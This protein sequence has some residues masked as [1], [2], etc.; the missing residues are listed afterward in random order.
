MSYP[1]TV[2]EA[3]IKILRHHDDEYMVPV[4]HVQWGG[5]LKRF[6][7]LGR[8]V[9]DEDVGIV[10][11]VCTLAWPQQNRETGGFANAWPAIL[12]GGEGGGEDDGGG[13][14]GGKR[15]GELV[16]FS[17]VRTNFSN[18]GSGAGASFSGVRNNFSNGG[19]AIGI[20]TGKLNQGMN[21]VKAP[22]NGMNVHM[23][24][25]PLGEG[26]NKNAP[27]ATP[28]KPPKSQCGVMSGGHTMLP[29]LSDGYEED[30]RFKGLSIT[31]PE[32]FPKLPKGAY[33]IAIA[34]T[35]EYEQKNLFF[36][37]DPRLYAVNYKGDPKMG[38]TVYDLD[39][40]FRVDKKRGA[41]IQAAWRV[42]KEPLGGA[43]TLALQLGPTGCQD[44]E[45]GYV[46]DL[47]QGSGK[48]AP[49]GATQV[50]EELP[51]AIGRLSANKGGPIAVGSQTDKHNVGEDADGTK[52][53]KAHIDTQALFRK[54]DN[55]D[56]PLKFEGP[57]PIPNMDLEKRIDCHISWSDGLQMWYVWTTSPLTLVSWV[58]TFPPPSTTKPGTLTPP[59]ES[60]SYPKVNLTP[61]GGLTVSNGGIAGSSASAGPVSAAGT[62]AGSAPSS[63]T[64]GPEPWP[65][66]FYPPGTDPGFV[67]PPP[68]WSG[69][70]QASVVAAEINPF[71]T[72]STIVG[73]GFLGTNSAMAG[74]LTLAQSMSW[75]AAGAQLGKPPVNS[76]ISGAMSAFGAQ[77]GETAGGTLTSGGPTA[78]A[79]VGASGDPWVYNQK[80]GESRYATGT[81]SGGWI[82]HPP[83][84][85]PADQAS[86]SMVP[87]NTT[88]SATYMLTS[89]GAYFAAGTPNL[90]TGGVMVGWSWGTEAATGDL[91][92]RAHSGTALQTGIRFILSTQDIAWYSAAGVYGALSHTNTGNRTYS[93]PDYSG[94]I[95][96][97]VTGSGTPVGT[98]TAPVSTMYWD[99]S[100]AV[101]Y[102]NNDS[103]TGW[104]ALSPAGGG[105]APANA[106]YLT[107][108]LDG[109]LT[110]ERV[111][112]AGTNITFT[113]T[114][115]NGTLTINSTGG[116][117]IT[118]SGSSGHV[119]YWTGVSSIG[120]DS[121]FVYDPA[122]DRLTIMGDTGTSQLR[123]SYD[124]SNYTE[125]EVGSDGGLHL[126]ST[127]N[128]VGIDHAVSGGMS[129]FYVLN[130]SNTADSDTVL[131]IAVGGGSG[132]NPMLVYTGTGGD[133][134]LG[135]ETSN[136]D[137]RIV[138]E[139]YL[140]TGNVFFTLSTAGNLGIG[141]AALGL[142]SSMLDIRGDNA[143]DAAISF[144]N[145]NVTNP[146]YW[147]MGPATGNAAQFG[148]YDE[149][150]T[151]LGWSV[152]NNTGNM[153][154]GMSL[155]NRQLEVRDDDGD[156]Q[157]RL[158]YDGSNYTEF[159]DSSDG[160]TYVA[161]A[162]SSAGTLFIYEN[163]RTS[164]NEVSSSNTS[165][166]AG[167]IAGFGAYVA[168][169]T[170]DDPYIQLTISGVVDWFIHV[171]NSQSDAFSIGRTF[172][173]STSDFVITT[174]GLVGVGTSVPGARL[175]VL[176]TTTQLRL[177]YDAAVYSEFTVSGSGNVTV[178]QTGSYY[179]FNS[180]LGLNVSPLRPLHVEQAYAGNL[181]FRASHSATRYADFGCNTT[182]DMMLESFSM[183]VSLGGATD[184]GS[185]AGVLALK[186]AVTAPTAD[187]TGGV[188]LYSEGGRLKARTPYG[189]FVLTPDASEETSKVYRATT[190]F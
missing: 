131:E 111:L 104:T 10:D 100:G 118:G 2:A 187:T 136:D 157:L 159:R 165:N 172:V 97:V 21:P 158:S 27:V 66:E 144:N 147:T 38:S 162:S 186:D 132:G 12:A 99:I 149:T 103:S 128:Y 56:G 78:A 129:Q 53:N 119:T 23:D 34:G 109:T 42:V 169:S 116:G 176:S 19:A 112:T 88:L 138:Q 89:P 32:G 174:G 183:N 1:R 189:V 45:G 48:A 6:D 126:T 127:A 65:K 117:G 134:S 59:P 87:P 49:K 52:I 46:Y 181:Q 43:N 16:S 4:R 143:L 3:G 133:W 84:T 25:Q 13:S 9:F 120:G 71:P 190:F 139:T 29:V 28:G 173:A 41:P 179:R 148:L 74:P 76:P 146:R 7:E 63:A 40:K 142:S 30:A 141:T 57:L 145:T 69:P 64:T 92:W 39:D 22:Q 62:T 153:G 152:A 5:V 113:D 188:V 125:F 15:S 80:P 83:E 85:S 114:G 26:G 115:A 154:V 124:G 177:S 151:R 171:D 121:M 67:G 50:A 72:K 105:S 37:T 70:L 20:D 160:Q 130:S 168:G 161:S 68:E 95:G 135:V 75:G 36:P 167:A 110:S 86:Y 102:A 108:S 18:G 51:Y 44:T 33:G 106:T 163:A 91:V 60:V 122:N 96:I 98:I 31:L 184:F 180:N 35:Y 93:F 73:Q 170:A 55:E 107:L 24:P 164:Y 81:S 166:T 101:M 185:G 178:T 182:G 82:I 77:G 94:P 79:L 47:S 14:E 175:G 140:L 155:A 17:G 137:F 90:A 54:N 156:P 61:I 58:P 150:G 8:A 123:L 11:E